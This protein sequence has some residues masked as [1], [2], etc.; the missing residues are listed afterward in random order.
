MKPFARLVRWSAVA[1]LAVAAVV[2]GVSAA[3]HSTAAKADSIWGLTTVADGSGTSDST[4]GAQPL[5]DTDGTATVT[6][7]DSI[8]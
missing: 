2:T 7:R 8:W 1:L 6:A 5:S 3:Q 4:D